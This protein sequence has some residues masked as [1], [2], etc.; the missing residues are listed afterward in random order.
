MMDQP[1]LT[2]PKAVFRPLIRPNR[3]H[4]TS[5]HEPPRP[6]QTKH[7]LEG[8]RTAH[9]VRAPACP[10]AD[11]RRFRKDHPD[12]SGQ[13]HPS[14]GS[15]DTRQGMTLRT[16]PLP[17]ARDLTP[18]AQAV[19][20]RTLSRI[21]THYPQLLIHI[22]MRHAPPFHDDSETDMRYVEVNPAAD[23]SD[24]PAVIN[25]NPLPRSGRPG[26]HAHARTEKIFPEAGQPWLSCLNTARAPPGSRRGGVPG[27]LS[28]RPDQR[29]LRSWR[30]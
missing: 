8:S 20:E 10:R 29:T 22:F 13:S 14:R 24:L 27:P 3:T 2:G 15:P 1:D 18:P 23:P 16:A 21:N 30:W 5:P 25:T 4:R 12:H 6:K 19:Q 17:V 28:H 26:D 9:A 11:G 7:A